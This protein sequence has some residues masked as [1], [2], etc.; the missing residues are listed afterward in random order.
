MS[1]TTLVAS[2][3]IYR[4]GNAIGRETPQTREVPARVVEL[5]WQRRGLQYTASGYGKKIPTRYQVEIAGKWRRVYCCIYSNSGTCYIGKFGGE[6]QQL[7]VSD[8]YEQR[9]QDA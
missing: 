5:E 4:N 9:A 6:G 8:V 3:S 7:L 2:I 1:N